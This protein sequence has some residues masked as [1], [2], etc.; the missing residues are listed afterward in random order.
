MKTDCRLTL[1][2]KWDDAAVINTENDATNTGDDDHSVIGSDASS[3]SAFV[4]RGVLR[5]EWDDRAAPCPRREEQ[6]RDRRGR[7]RDEGASVLP[8]LERVDVVGAGHVRVD[9]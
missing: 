9:S 1:F 8:F 2:S 3:P 7:R 6:Q 5:G 4:V